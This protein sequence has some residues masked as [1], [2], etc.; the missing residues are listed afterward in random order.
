MQPDAT[1]VGG[2]KGEGGAEHAPSHPTAG[3]EHAP[4]HPTAGAPP[5]PAPPES[6]LQGD[7][8]RDTQQGE[9]GKSWCR[10]HFSNT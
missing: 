2:L 8:D 1:R 4:S 10:L 5:W 3:A 9:G 7:S 6:S